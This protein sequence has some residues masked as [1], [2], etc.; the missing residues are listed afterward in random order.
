MLLKDNSE[1]CFLLAFLTNFTFVAWMLCLHVCIISCITSICKVAI[2]TNVFFF[3]GCCGKDFHSMLQGHPHLQGNSLPLIACFLHM[4]IPR[5]GKHPIG[6]WRTL[7]SYRGFAWGMEPG[8]LLKLA[9]RFNL[10][11]QTV[12]TIKKITFTG[13]WRHR[14]QTYVLAPRVQ[15]CHPKTKPTKTNQQKPSWWSPH[16]HSISP[17][18]C[19]WQ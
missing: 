9:M 13:F 4:R 5:L 15:K 10:S 17:V 18:V 3:S 16:Q 8:K 1:F 12:Q 14:G 19:S 7:E 2:I 11:S 6:F